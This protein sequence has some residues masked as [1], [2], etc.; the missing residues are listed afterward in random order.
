MQRLYNY[1]PLPPGLDASWQNALHVLEH[2]QTCKP[3]RERIHQEICDLAP[4]EPFSA[5][6]W[7]KHAPG[8]LQLSTV[9]SDEE[10]LLRLAACIQ[11][12]EARRTHYAERNLQLP[13]LP[14]DN[15]N[16]QLNAY[17]Q[18]RLPVM[19]ITTIPPLQP[20]PPK[21]KKPHKDVST[22]SAAPCSS[23]VLTIQQISLSDRVP[24]DPTSIDRLNFITLHNH[25]S[26]PWKTS[27][28]VYHHLLN[29]ED[30][31]M[32]LL[33]Q[34]K[35]RSGGTHRNTAILHEALIIPIILKPL[36][37]NQDFCQILESYL[38]AAG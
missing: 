22:L 29:R 27:H 36:D 7:H 20:L 37:D 4:G 11:R 38:I 2:L 3:E 6:I 34:A 12:E 13:S 25:T 15:W 16:Q 21:P 8:I 33:Q 18:F 35:I 31:R 30:L 23:Q 24:N 17:P 10:F 32:V 5:I 1:H 9:N 19:T 14:D 26:K 28:D